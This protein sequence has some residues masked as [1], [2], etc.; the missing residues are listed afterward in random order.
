MA[1]THSDGSFVGR[2]DELGMVIEHLEGDGP[3]PVLFLHGVAGIG[4]TALLREVERRI[5]R[6]EWLWVEAP[7]LGSEPLPA[8]AADVVIVDGHEPIHDDAVKS[9]LGAVLPAGARAVVAGRRPPSPAWHAEGWDSVLATLEVGPLGDDASEDLVRMSRVTDPDTVSRL[10]RWSKGEPLALV[11]S[12]AASRRPGFDPDELDTDLELASRL[13]DRIFTRDLRSASAPFRRDAMRVLGVAAVAR[14]VDVSTL[15]AVVPDLD[16]AGWFEWLEGLSVSRPLGTRLTLDDRLRSAFRSQ[17]RGAHPEEYR[18]VRRRLADH[19]A[20]LASGGQ[21]RYLLE[22]AELI[23]A[24]ELAWG[25]GSEAG[26][27]LRVDPARP[28]DAAAAAVH[29][30]DQPRRWAGLQRWF[31]EAPDHVLVIRDAEGELVGAAVSVGLDDTPE[32]AE[33]D[34]VVAPWLANARAHHDPAEAVLLRDALLFVEGDARARVAAVGNAAVVTGRAFD[35]R[36]FYVLIEPDDDEKVAFVNALGYRRCPELDVADSEHLLH[37]YVLDLGRGGFVGITRDLVYRD[38]GLDPSDV[39][40]GPAVSRGDVADALRAFHEPAVLLANPLGGDKTGEARVRVARDRIRR[41]TEEAF[42][43][44]EVDRLRRAVL[45][46]G[47]LAPDSSHARAASSLH[48]SRATYFRRL[49]E[50]VDRIADHLTGQ[51]PSA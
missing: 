46:R 32:W 9:L 16:P 45:E 44:D 39:P 50:G 5:G 19:T 15:S 31:R 20:G 30:A 17:L 11:E 35:A 41:A 28:D 2:D 29:F 13:V 49:S 3:R 21:P 51:E 37:S 25:M 1:T 48:L 40:S 10:V 47:Y 7:E 18:E 22:L 14:G 24:P 26:A 38:L 42:G 12:A 34:P 23:D 36:W 27:E 33:G 43:V 6:E 4:K 8:S